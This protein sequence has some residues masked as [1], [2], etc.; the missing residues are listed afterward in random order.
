MTTLTTARTELADLLSQI[1]GLRITP[2]PTGNNLRSGDGWVNVVS[3]QPLDFTSSTAELAAVIVLGSDPTRADERMDE[4][5]VPVVDKITYGCY[6]TDVRLV[7]EIL[8]AGDAGQ[9][10]ALYVA[11]C[12]V[13]VEVTAT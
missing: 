2:R 8:L 9:T 1:D 5:A 7:P 10:G 12:S 4:I 13:T 11:T 3:V 6:S